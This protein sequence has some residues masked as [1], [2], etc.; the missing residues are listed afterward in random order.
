MIDKSK[1]LLS[2]GEKQLMANTEWILTK[3]RIID[4]INLLFGELAVVMQQLVTIQGQHL[5]ATVI[6]PA[7]KIAKGENYR[8]L[9]YVILDYPRYFNKP[10]IFAIRTM[11]WWGHFFSCSLHLSGMYK[12]MFV[13]VLQQNS[14][15]I[16]Q[17]DWHICV[18]EEEWEH[19]FETDNYIA[20]NTVTEEKL[21]ALLS[22]QHFIKVAAKFELHQWNEIDALLEKSFSAMLQLLKN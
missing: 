19:H 16:R 7:A 15:L 18:N 9:P 3:R 14:H 10:D 21:Y 17:H 22:Q 5:P 6:Q 1:L 8:Q 13:E 12:T 2:N 4:T 11:F 20:A